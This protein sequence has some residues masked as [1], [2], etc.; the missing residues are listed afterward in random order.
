MGVYSLSKTLIKKQQ[1]KIPWRQSLFCLFQEA[2]VS[3]VVTTDCEESKKLG[4]ILFFK[5]NSTWNKVNSN[6]L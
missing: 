5:L 6:V 4:H 1:I 2:A 3:Y